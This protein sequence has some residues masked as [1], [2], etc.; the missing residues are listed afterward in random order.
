MQKIMS[1]LWLTLDRAFK[2]L[3]GPWH[4]VFQD[5]QHPQHE[6]RSAVTHIQFNRMLKMSCRA[7]ELVQQEKLIPKS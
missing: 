2:M 5:F 1:I 7:V 4:S 6:L 3:F